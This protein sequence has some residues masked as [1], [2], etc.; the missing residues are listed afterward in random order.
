MST[1]RTHFDDKVKKALLEFTKRRPF[2]VNTQSS[3]Y[4]NKNKVDMAYKNF[5]DENNLN[6]KYNGK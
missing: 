6:D 1:Q 3:E 2:L 5:L 4:M